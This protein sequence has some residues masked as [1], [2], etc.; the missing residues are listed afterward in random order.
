MKEITKQKLIEFNKEK[1]YSIADAGII[2]TILE[3]GKVVWE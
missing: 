2:E 3:C 1:N